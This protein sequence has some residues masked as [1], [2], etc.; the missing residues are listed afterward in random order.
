MSVGNIGP[1]G[2]IYPSAVTATRCTPD[3]PMAASDGVQPGRDGDAASIS[4]EGRIRSLLDTFMGGAGADGVITGDEV[5]SFRDQNLATVQEVLRQAFKDLSIESR[6]RTQIDVSPFGNVIVTGSLPEESRQK[7][8]EALQSSH[9]F[10]SAYAAASSAATALKA[11]EAASDFH[12]AYADDPVTAVARYRWLFDTD[13]DFN[14]F[15]E[16]DRVGFEVAG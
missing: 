6:G 8:Q 13:W 4:H 10:R 9:E 15:F 11:F 7:L 5:R 12:S 3:S 2:R 16:R 14:L 1:Q